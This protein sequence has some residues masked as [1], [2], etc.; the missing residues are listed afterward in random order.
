MEC[1]KDMGL[2]KTKTA[3]ETPNEWIK[4]FENARKSPSPFKV[5]KVEQDMIRDWTEFFNDNLYAN[6]CPFKTRP[7][8]EVKEE[9]GD[10]QNLH[11]STYNGAWSSSSMTVS[12][13]ITNASSSSTFLEPGEFLYPQQA[14]DGK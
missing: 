5:V 4:V 11:R 8:K 6:K 14:Y 10:L 13:K 1:D 12:R 2:I 3:V 9:K 7:L